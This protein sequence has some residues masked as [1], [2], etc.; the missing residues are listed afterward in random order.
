MR[1]KKKVHRNRPLKVLLT[2]EEMAAFKNAFNATSFR[3]I[4]VYARSL[5]FGKP[6]RVSFRNQSLDEFVLMAA[7][8]KDQLDAVARNCTRAVKLLQDL[9]AT[10]EV[11]E[12]LT[13]I[14][15]EEFELRQDIQEIKFLLAKI[16]ENVLQIQDLRGDG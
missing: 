11:S 1:P 14:L 10:G 15:S 3:R 4:S 9:N 7:S 5:L 13:L 16:Y 2:S 12:T 6:V 8:I